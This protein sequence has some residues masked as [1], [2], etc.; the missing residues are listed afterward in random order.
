MFSNPFLV[1]KVARLEKRLK[2]ENLTESGLDNRNSER[3]VSGLRLACN[4]IL[5]DMTTYS[6]CAKEVLLDLTLM[7]LM[8]K[9]FTKEKLVSCTDS[10]NRKTLLRESPLLRGMSLCDSSPRIYYNFQVKLYAIVERGYS[11]PIG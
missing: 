5:V 10:R 9:K 3:A 1:I 4:R 6:N 2:K 7:H 8:V 11:H